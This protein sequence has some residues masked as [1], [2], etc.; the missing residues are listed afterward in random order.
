MMLMSIGWV[1]RR[2][3]KCL[4]DLDLL[5]VVIRACPDQAAKN[6][7]VVLGGFVVAES[8]MYIVRGFQLLE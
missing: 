3:G 1:D 5:E 4:S 2:E 6:G 8:A 7:I